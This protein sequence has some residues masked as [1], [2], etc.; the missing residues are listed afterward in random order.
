MGTGRSEA[1]R[2]GA[3]ERGLA[4]CFDYCTF[5][6]TDDELVNVNV[7]VLRLLPPLEQAPDQIASRPLDTLSVMLVPDANDAAPLLPGLTLTPDGVNVTRS[8]LRPVAVTVSVAL[9]AAE[10]VGRRAEPRSERPSGWCHCK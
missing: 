5:A 4:G 3:L 7:H 9:A 6:A 1:I 2:R 8:P 10:M